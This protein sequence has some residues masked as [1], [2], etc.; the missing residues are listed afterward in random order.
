MQEKNKKIVKPSI[1]LQVGDD[2][3]H[4]YSFY[5]VMVSELTKFKE[6]IIDIAL[7]LCNTR[8]K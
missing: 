1:I 3:A 6:G 2:I 8:S 7:K 5:K 4:I